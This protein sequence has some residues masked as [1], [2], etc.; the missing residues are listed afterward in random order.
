MAER[1]LEV[2]AGTEI[3][4]TGAVNKPLS[5][6]RILL[7]G[8]EPIAAAIAADAAGNEQ[9]TFHIA[10][11]D[12][13]ASVSG[14]YR[15]EL[16]D[17]D[18]VA[19]VV[20]QW[21]L[22]VQPD[23]PPTATWQRPTDDLYVTPGAVLPIEVLVKDNLSIQRV[24]LIYDRSDRSE[25]ERE[26]EPTE[27]PIELYRGPQEPTAVAGDSTG[28]RGESRVVDYAWDLSPLK[29][30]VGAQLTIHAEAADYRPAT[31]PT[32]G[33]RRITI[34]TPEN[35]NRPSTGAGVSRRAIDPRRRPPGRDPATRRRHVDRRRP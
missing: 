21:N 34:I 13:I 10:P 2:L 9:C 26:R 11:H 20:G 3:E 15:L 29:L 7:E 12:W 1:H 28:G 32:A 14:P 16:T 18:G 8:R 31:G 23:T 19:G 30:P 24:D 33:P 25:A 6:A 17:A 22:R 35:P 4:M 5:A 27:K